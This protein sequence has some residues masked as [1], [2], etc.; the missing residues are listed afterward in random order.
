MQPDT[1]RTRIRPKKPDMALYVPRARREIAVSKTSTL[2][3][4]R[5]DREVNRGP[6]GK[7]VV[8]GHEARTSPKAGRGLLHREQ[9]GFLFPQEEKRI[10]SRDGFPQSSSN[11]KIQYKER[12]Q[13]LRKPKSHFQVSSPGFL[14]QTPALLP[15]TEL[16]APL[17]CSTVLST[18]LLRMAGLQIQP[19]LPSV[20]CTW[21]QKH[22]FPS[23]GQE[24]YST[25]MNKQAGAFLPDQVGLSEEN[26]LPCA[27]ER[28]SD[29]T[30]MSEKSTLAGKVKDLSRCDLRPTGGSGDDTFE[31]TGSREVHKD[32]S[33]KCSSERISDEADSNN[34]I[35]GD[36]SNTHSTCKWID[37]CSH[38]EIDDSSMLEYAPKRVPDET[39]PKEV[40]ITEDVGRNV[41]APVEVNKYSTLNH[42][43]ES[44]SGAYSHAAEHM[45][46]QNMNNM[47]SCVSESM[48][49]QTVTS[50]LAANAVKQLSGNSGV[51]AG[52]LDGPCG[53]LDG[54][55]SCMFK[56]GELGQVCGNEKRDGFSL[57]ICQCKPSESE[58]SVT[59]GNAT[60]DLGG[61]N[62]HGKHNPEASCSAKE[63][64]SCLQ[65]CTSKEIIHLSAVGDPESTLDQAEAPLGGTSMEDPAQR[66]MGM[67]LQHP[68][69][70]RAEGEAEPSV[71]SSWEEPTGTS[72]GP[73]TLSED[74]N[75]ANETWDSL[76]NDDGDCLDP[77]LL[78]GLSGH[79]LSPSGLQ[80]PRFDYYS[81]SP[82]NLDLSDS[83]FPHVIEIYDFPPEFRTEDLLH[84]FCSYQK[85][86]FDIKW[87]DDTHA[88]GIFS[89][90]IAAQDA[91]STKHLLVKTRP[92][93]QAT[94]AAKSKA[95][96][97]A[98]FL[99]PAKERPET[100]A[101][102]ARRLVT[103][104]LGVRSKQSKAEREAERQQL[105]A[106]RERKR[107]EA[108]QREDAWEGHE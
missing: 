81:Y 46:D 2:L 61:Q 80:E 17:E 3:A 47:S 71:P 58:A 34:S 65:E 100:S 29:Q 74:G 27:S 89:S 54:L 42:E 102:L 69:G 73:A 78:E 53:R 51:A 105:Q 94:R 57:H 44:K 43:E 37:S 21:E 13:P 92:L 96:S 76:F 56:E 106:A 86:G 90:P 98:E 35:L 82:A 15:N 19:G 64:A 12:P 55:P 9:G 79:A 85:K 20:D 36:I 70:D 67:K 30:E 39:D 66:N 28:L 23:A 11:P 93:S 49:I 87:V 1:E 84:V 52:C 22:I 33:S 95:R 14:S 8:K 59:V 99:Q 38:T 68:S 97:Y 7:E 62:S 6:S 50:S 5:S 45:S 91:L 83:E 4:T 101:A 32:C 77:Q 18:G 88:L 104:A 24:T 31:N 10:T 41:L 40:S 48:L 25:E 107:L 63:A 16:E 75:V 108:K 26:V 103:G 72:V 60:F